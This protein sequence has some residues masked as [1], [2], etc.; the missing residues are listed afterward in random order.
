[1]KSFYTFFEQAEDKALEPP[2]RVSDDLVTTFGR[3]NPPHLGHKL[4]LD[5]ADDIAG[6]IG[7][8][9]PADQRFHSSRSFDP[10]TNPLPF[11][12][13]MQFLKKMFPDHAEK[14]DE[15]PNNRTILNAATKAHGEG[16]KNFHFVGG[17]DRQKPMEDLLRKYNG[18][19]YDFDNIYSHSAGERMDDGEDLLAKLSASRQRKHAANNDFDGF[20]EGMPEH[21]DFGRTD[22]R[23]LFQLL[24]QFGQKNEDWEID[25]RGNQELIRELY[26]GGHLFQEGDLV[27][28]LSSGLVGTVRRCGANH[29]IC[30]TEEGIMFKNFIHDLQAV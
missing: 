25:R 13:K 26:T 22:A 15:D 21:D 12:M 24:Q 28:S 17:G 1:M 6:S 27:E 7:D 19:F 30:V 3:H 2:T 8:D 20:M 18:D 14:W 9:T 4:G 10:K 23:E 11:E 29:L 5:M 16:Y